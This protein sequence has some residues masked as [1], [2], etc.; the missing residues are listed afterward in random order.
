MNDKI[1]NDEI[2]SNKIE[3]V[4]KHNNN[5]ATN[6]AQHEIKITRYENVFMKIVFPFLD[7]ILLFLSNTNIDK[8]G[9]TLDADFKAKINRM[10]A[11]LNNARTSKDF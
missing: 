10:R 1:I 2:I 7:E 9:G 11:Q 5:Q 4:I 6:I 8:H 3:N